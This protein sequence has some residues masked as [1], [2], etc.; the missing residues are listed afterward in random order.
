MVPQWKK[1]IYGLVGAALV[2]WPLLQYG[3]VQTY[4]MNA[5]RFFGWAMYA[6]PYP[7]IYLVVHDDKNVEI[8]LSVPQVK[9]VADAFSAGRVHYGDLLEPQELSSFLL[10]EDTTRERVTIEVS[11]VFLDA[12]SGSIKERKQRYVYGR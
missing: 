8:D 2:V 6:V 4:H 5:W 9:P 12:E 7:V 10:T 3:M 1:R 11:T